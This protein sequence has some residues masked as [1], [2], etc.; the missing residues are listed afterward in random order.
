MAADTISMT[1]LK[2]LFLLHQNGESQRNIAK[3]IGISKNTVKKYIRLAK[4]KG[5]E[6]QDLVQQEDYEQE[7]LFA[8]PGIESRDRERDLEPFYPYLDKVLKDT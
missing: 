8:E 3:V 6:V 1:K 4:L 2:Q 5:N 7:K